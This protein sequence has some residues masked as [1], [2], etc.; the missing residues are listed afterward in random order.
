MRVRSRMI[1]IVN[2]NEKCIICAQDF[3]EDSPISRVDDCWCRFHQICL[4]KWLNVNMICPLHECRIT[5][6]NEK[7][8]RV[9]NFEDDLNLV[10]M[11]EALLIDG[12][13]LN[14]GI[15]Q[16][17]K[18]IRGWMMDNPHILNQITTLSL[19]GIG[20]TFLPP[21]INF[22][23]N[24]T[25]LNLS[26]NSILALP[27]AL[28]LPKL[29]KLVLAIT[30]LPDDLD[31]RLPNLEVLDL[32]YSELLA[33]PDPFYHSNLTEL[34]LSYTEIPAL[35]QLEL[36]NLKILHL[37]PSTLGKV[38]NSLKNKPDLTIYPQRSQGCTRC[39]LA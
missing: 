8:I 26:L 20:L 29:K 27:D 12:L 31:R 39:I 37:D 18:T 33:L 23:E 19:I 25:E 24:L 10:R 7:P 22:F 28:Y 6:I 14:G 4:Q 5:S 9:P 34:D 3:V 16:K 36:P 17:A 32:S 13:T 35:G 2:V 21:E 15:I 11:F 1:Q 30:E 38:P